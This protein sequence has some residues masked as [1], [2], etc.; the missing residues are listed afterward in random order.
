M[1]ESRSIRT[2]NLKGSLSRRVYDVYFFQ[3]VKNHFW[4]FALRPVIN[5]KKWSIGFIVVDWCL[6]VHRVQ[7]FK[8]C[9]LYNLQNFTASQLAS[10][11]FKYWIHICDRFRMIFYGCEND[12]GILLQLYHRAWICFLRRNHLYLADVS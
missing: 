1:S 2:T 12:V 8:F 5:L 9:T 10:W 3:S 6:R 11:D 4:L 7:T